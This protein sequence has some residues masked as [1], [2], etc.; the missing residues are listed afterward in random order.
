MA[1]HAQ[2]TQPANP[3]PGS[4]PQTELPSKKQL[5]C[6]FPISETKNRP[7]PGDSSTQTVGVGHGGYDVSQ[8]SKPLR[9]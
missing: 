5:S 2:S 4:G 7:V 8:H 9:T 1:K 6:S 3:D